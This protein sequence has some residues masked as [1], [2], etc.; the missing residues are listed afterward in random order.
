MELLSDALQT[1]QTAP[2]QDAIPTLAS[3]LQYVDDITFEEYRCTIT[4]LLLRLATHEPELMLPLNIRT[5][6]RSEVMVCLN[7]FQSSE[8]V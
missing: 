3:T 2:P 7:K 6:S 8:N 4:L 1:M 5:A